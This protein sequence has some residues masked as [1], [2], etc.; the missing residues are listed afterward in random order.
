MDLG[1]LC[2]NEVI[3]SKGSDAVYRV[4][5]IS[6]KRVYI[7]LFNLITQDMPF[8]SLFSDLDGSLLERAEDPSS[9]PAIDTFL[10]VK[11][12]EAR[13]EI[14]RLMEPIVKNQPAIYIPKERSAIIAALGGKPDRKTVYKYLRQ[15]WLGGL[16]PNCFIPNYRKRGFHGEFRTPG[17]GVQKLGR[18]SLAGS[19]AGM[20]VTPE[21]LEIFKK[22]YENDYFEGGNLKDAYKKMVADSFIKLVDG[23]YIQ[24]EAHPSYGQYAY[25]YH[26]L[27][28]KKRPPG[29]PK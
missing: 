4:L 14:W 21:I 29:I 17:A 25:W 20:N 5:W 28:D 12:K 1:T 8:V 9:V 2:V 27:H 6:Y 19:D 10:S 15:Y 3:K 13:N 16:V 24:E 26:K 11:A 7:S 22:S 18:P 23:Q